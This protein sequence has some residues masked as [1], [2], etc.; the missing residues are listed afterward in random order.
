MERRT[1]RHIADMEIDNKPIS[2]ITMENGEDYIS[3]TCL[4]RFKSLE[5]PTK[6]ISNWMRLK[7]TI[8]YLSAWEN[9][10]NVEFKPLT[11]E[12]FEN[13]PMSTQ[14]W[15]E[16]THAKGLYSRSG[17]RGGTYAHTDIA[18]EFAMWVDVHFK[19]HVLREYQKLKRDEAVKKGDP[20]WIMLRELTK[21]GNH[22]LTKAIE[23]YLL[24]DGMSVYMKSAVH[25]TEMDMMNIAVFNKTAGEWK[26]ENDVEW[27]AL[28]RNMRNTATD[29]ELKLLYTLEGYAARL[30]KKGFSRDDR[31]MEYVDYIND[32]RELSE[33]VER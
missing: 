6:V 27:V 7:G 11:T 8:E 33:E 2:V 30:I 19:L 15:I 5:D 16:R 9:M 18:L 31:M 28:H 24:E 25:A 12:G 4:A 22:L 29:N 3:L 10:F 26:K 13:S 23:K 14:R 1:N 21:V 20:E 17:N 32:M